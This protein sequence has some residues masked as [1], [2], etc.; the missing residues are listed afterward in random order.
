[1]SNLGK[2][3]SYAMQKRNV[4]MPTTHAMKIFMKKTQ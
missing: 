3:K 2:F 4:Q 1:M